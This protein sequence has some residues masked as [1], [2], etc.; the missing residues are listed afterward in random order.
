MWMV[1]CNLPQKNFE[2][3]MDPEIFHQRFL[4]AIEDKNNDLFLMLLPKIATRNHEFRCKYFYTAGCEGTG[5]MVEHLLKKVQPEYRIIMTTLYDAMNCNNTDTVTVLAPRIADNISAMVSAHICMSN[6]INPDIIKILSAHML[7]GDFENMVISCAKR[8][9]NLEEKLETLW[10]FV[11]CDRF[12]KTYSL[13][14]ILSIQQDNNRKFLQNQHNTFQAHSQKMVLQDHI[15][16]A[17]K[18]SQRK[19]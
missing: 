18:P 13:N 12:F 2:N 14:H 11:D 6:R 16:A 17:G 19:I 5:V 10:Q 7:D 4:E 8:N 9:F 1:V 3:C 15:G